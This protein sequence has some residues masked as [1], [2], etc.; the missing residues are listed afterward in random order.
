MPKSEPKKKS[1]PPASVD[2]FL[3]ALDHPRKAELEALRA[4][5]PSVDPS[6]AEGIKWNAPSWRTSEWFATANVHAKSE[7]RLVLHLGAKKTA[8]SESGAA[9]DDPTRLLTWLG[10]DRAIVAFASADDFAAK[11]DPLAAIL[12]QWIRLI[13]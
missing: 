4:L 6:I 1:A 8:V 12:R 7:L 13:G 11:R 5:I 9:I 2:A 3:A 10:N